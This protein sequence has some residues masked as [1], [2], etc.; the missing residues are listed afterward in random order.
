MNKLF[1]SF[2]SVSVLF[3]A[4]AVPG[5]ALAQHYPAGAHPRTRPMMPPPRTLTTPP[6]LVASPSKEVV[7]TV[8]GEQFFIVAS[9]DKQNSQVLLKRPTEVTVLVKI[10]SKTK[11]FSDSGKPETLA[12]FRAGDTVW[13]KLSGDGPEPSLIQMRQGEMS[14]ADLH[15]YFLDYPIIK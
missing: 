5:A 1:R 2:A 13:V 9:I 6:R 11:Y 14:L 7:K 12:N 4:A 15:R 10:D 8:S 3:F